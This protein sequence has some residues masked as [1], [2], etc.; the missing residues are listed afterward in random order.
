MDDHPDNV[1]KL[2][3]DREQDVH[4]EEQEKQEENT[5]VIP[6]GDIDPWPDPV[7]GATEVLYPMVR[8]L[9]THL[10][11][12]EGIPETIALYCTFTHMVQSADCEYAPRLFL[13]SPVKRCGKTQ[14]M[15]ICTHFVRRPSPSGNI[16][17]ASVFREVHYF[18]PTLLIDELDTF[19]HGKPELVGVLNSG[20]YRPFAFVKR[21]EKG[22]PVKYRTFAPVIF[23]AIGTLPKEASALEDRCI[24]LPFRRRGHNE[25]VEKLS[26]IG[27]RSQPLT[28]LGRK[29][30]RWVADN[31]EALTR[32]D[33]MMPE[34]LPDRAADN[35]RSLFAIADLAGGEWPTLA[36]RTALML[37]PRDETEQPETLLAYMS[38][39]FGEQPRIRTVELLQRLHE[40]E[41]FGSVTATE[42]AKILKPFGI[43]SKFM[44]F[45]GGRSVPGAHGYENNRRFRDAVERYAATDA[46]Y[47]PETFTPEPPPAVETPPEAR[48]TG[49]TDTPTESAC[50][51]VANGCSGV[52]G[53]APEVEDTPEVDPAQA[54]RDAARDEAVEM[55]LSY[56]ADR[57]RD[58]SRDAED[59]QILRERLADEND[60]KVSKADLMAYI[61]KYAPLK[62]G[63]KA[64]P[65]SGD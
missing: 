1:V 3:L 18:A 59:V 42:L 20:H 16:T 12:N 43:Q 49:Y 28:D 65:R 50:I 26:L 41:G 61:R 11:T 14:A 60:I 7:D 55:I 40:I 27:G 39:I 33:P 47:V 63:R 56:Y 15:T 25:K 29:A 9:N 19:V 35:W 38:V 22:V 64:A 54:D 36:R 62:V 21:I 51:G 30:A 23:G 31:L 46:V 24:I 53:V 8:A 58:R 10:S 52:A 45:S 57:P 44:R 32:A 6:E 5:V 17:M 13:S 34:R 37:T 48:D 4:E 2:H